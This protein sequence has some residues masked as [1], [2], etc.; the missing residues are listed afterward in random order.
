MLLFDR[1]PLLA[2]ADN[3]PAANVDLSSM[4]IVL[5]L[6]CTEL[7]ESRDNWDE[8]NDTEWDELEAQIATL[9]SEVT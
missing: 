3:T 7:L 8:M 5:I 9:V 4:S 6:A 1:V 2:L